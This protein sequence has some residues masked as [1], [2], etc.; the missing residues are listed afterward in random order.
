MLDA[1]DQ[2]SNDSLGAA[3][4][5]FAST[6]DV[7]EEHVLS[8]ITLMFIAGHETTA[9]T[10]SFFIYALCKHPDIQTKVY[11][12]MR[13][14]LNETGDTAYQSQP[15]LL[16]A[17]VEAVL[18]E[19]MRK[20][21]VAHGNVRQVT[22]DKGYDL[23]GIHLNKG[24]WILANAFCIHNSPAAWGDDVDEFKPERWLAGDDSSG[25]MLASAAIYSGGGQTKDSLSFFPFSFG[26][27]GCL[28]MNLA[29]L[30]IRAA[31]SRL[32][33]LYSFRLADGR[34]L[35][36]GYA[37][38]RHLTLRPRDKLAVIVEAREAPVTCY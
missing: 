27:R 10:L 9:H 4:L 14:Y 33:P 23:G 36:E 21:P 34:M 16:P 31:I 5:D 13:K 20:Y 11:A 3:I 7:H 30:E 19:S 35:D 2:L 8:E 15:S 24:T 25:N 12:E 37:L 38:E 22:S 1:K 32:V 29:L 6:P 28:G 26:P 18:K 17:Y